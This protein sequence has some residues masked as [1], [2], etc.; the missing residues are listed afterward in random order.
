MTGCSL[1]E[2]ENNCLTCKIGYYIS[3][4]TNTKFAACKSIST[5][6]ECSSGKTNYLEKNI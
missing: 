2:V 5:L 1:C 6:S 4:D 3:V